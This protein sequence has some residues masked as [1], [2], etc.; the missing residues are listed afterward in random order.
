MDSK[1]NLKGLGSVMDFT[2]GQRLMSKI[3]ESPNAFIGLYLAN[4]K[5]W[6]NTAGDLSKSCQLLVNETSR[7]DW[8]LI[9][10]NN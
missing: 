4:S 9:G 10:N 7:D 1:Q 6:A 3:K 5:A 2:T 8:F